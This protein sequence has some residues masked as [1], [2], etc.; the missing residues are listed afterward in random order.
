M[1]VMKTLNYTKHRIPTPPYAHNLS[2][3]ITKLARFL[4]VSGVKSGCKADQNGLIK[5]IPGYDMI[6]YHDHELKIP[7]K[8]AFK[9]ALQMI[10]DLQGGFE[11]AD[12]FL[13]VQGC[14][15]IMPILA[16]F[17]VQGINPVN[18][19]AG[20]LRGQCVGKGNENE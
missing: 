9:A 18:L 12:N 11:N 8:T 20:I 4:H 16:C 17:G 10:N 6:H 1:P 13:L 5:G 14:K 7:P 3:L 2:L 15:L 19:T